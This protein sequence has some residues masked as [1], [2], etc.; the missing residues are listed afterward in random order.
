MLFLVVW[1]V[2]MGGDWCGVSGRPINVINPPL[3]ICLLRIQEEEDEEEE[4]GESGSGSSV[5]D[6]AEEFAGASSDEDDEEGEDSEV[7]GQR[8]GWMD[9]EWSKRPY[10]FL[11]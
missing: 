10:M 5:F 7:S 1:C 8:V 11:C 3:C 4:D 2:W 6:S 9:V